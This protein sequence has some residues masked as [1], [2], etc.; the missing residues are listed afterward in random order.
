M[1]IGKRIK[2]VRKERKITLKEL[3]DKIGYSSAYISQIENGKRSKPS[4]DFL[5]KVSDHLDISISYI[6]TGRKTVSDL[7]EEELKEQ[8]KVSTRLFNEKQERLRSSLKEE[9]KE[10]AEYDLSFNETNFLNQAIIFLKESTGPDLIILTS[11]LT[12]YNRN[13]NVYHETH[14]SEELYEDIEEMK[15]W[16]ETLFSTRYGLSEYM[17]NEED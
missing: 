7:T 13:E 12:Q 1:D 2:E 6:T 14:D 16:I 9:F 4:H 8:I 3:S 5:Q 15:K 11:I 17:R 10:L